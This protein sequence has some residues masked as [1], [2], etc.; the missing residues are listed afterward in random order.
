MLSACLPGAL[1]HAQSAP[2]LHEEV[3][4]VVSGQPVT[5]AVS[6]LQEW[7][8]LF[9]TTINQAIGL[10]LYGCADLVMARSPRQ[11]LAALHKTQR[12][13]LKHSAKTVGEIT[14]L[15][16]RQNTAVECSPALARST[17]G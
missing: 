3:V 8:Q 1:C 6:R 16:R 14:G 12:S 15:W 11:A 2:F 13:L 7:Q 17:K 5:A 4:S 9:G 10:Y